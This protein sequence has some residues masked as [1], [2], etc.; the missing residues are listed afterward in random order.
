MPLFAFAGWDVGAAA[1]TVV[2]V[3]EV[4]DLWTCVCCGTYE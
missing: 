1:V 2:I 4:W 3:V